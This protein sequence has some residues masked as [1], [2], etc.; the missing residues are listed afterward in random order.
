LSWGVRPAVIETE[1]DAEELLERA[2][3][4]AEEKGYVDHGEI[5][6]LTAGIPLGVSGTT[7]L[8]KVMVAGE[9]EGKK[10]KKRK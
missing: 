4:K 9:P 7:N 5:V 2:A 1:N 3:D 10:S 6:V 8:I